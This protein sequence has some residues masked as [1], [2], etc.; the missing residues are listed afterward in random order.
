MKLN[1]DA[2]PS[3]SLLSSDLI[4][5]YC[6]F[7]QHKHKNEHQILYTCLFSNNGYITPFHN[8]YTQ[9]SRSG[10]LIFVA[11]KLTDDNK[12]NQPFSPAVISISLQPH[13]Y[14]IYLDTFL[15]RLQFSTLVMPTGRLAEPPQT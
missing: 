10:Y 14:E 2:L 3:V 4:C 1:W 13:I 12:K 11:R 7:K 5:K 8:M 15:C 6:K 9:P